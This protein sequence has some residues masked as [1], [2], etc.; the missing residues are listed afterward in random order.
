MDWIY[1]RNLIKVRLAKDNRCAFVGRDGKRWK[2]GIVCRGDRQGACSK[3][4]E[5]VFLVFTVPMTQ[6]AT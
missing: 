2:G 6:N 1:V 4:I 5:N 3:L